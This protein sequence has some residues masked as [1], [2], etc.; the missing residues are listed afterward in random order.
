[1][2]KR[3][4]VSESEER[5]LTDPGHL[6]W[7]SLLKHAREQDEA[8][9]LR[10]EIQDFC[11]HPLGIGQWVTTKILNFQAKL[12]GFVLLTSMFQKMLPQTIIWICETSVC[13]F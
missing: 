8:L 6:L 4:N 10:L 9:K 2:Q 5:N 11:C 1:M 12:Q 3:K 7:E 13:R